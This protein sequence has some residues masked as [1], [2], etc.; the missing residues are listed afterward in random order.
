G[1]TQSIYVHPALPD[2]VQRAFGELDW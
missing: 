1:V 2:V